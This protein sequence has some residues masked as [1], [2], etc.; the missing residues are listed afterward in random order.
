MKGKNWQYVLLESALRTANFVRNKAL[1]YWSDNT[2][3]SKNSLQ[4]LCAILARDIKV[5][6]AASPYNGDWTYWSK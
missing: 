3:V 2:G 4:K 5:K 6:G 1:R